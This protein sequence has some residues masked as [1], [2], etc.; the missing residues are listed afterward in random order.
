MKLLKVI[1][2]QFSFQFESR[3]RLVLVEVLKRYPSI[4]PGHER[5]SPNSKRHSATAPALPEA[6]ARLLAEAL[7][8]QRAENRRQVRKWLSDPARM[9]E[10]DSHWILKVPADQM[11]WLLQV[12]NEVRVGSWLRLGAPEPKEE[13]DLINEKTA[14]DFWA[15]DAAG[16]LQARFLEALEEQGSADGS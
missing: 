11:E 4:P 12:L 6:T 3:E 5:M 14:A 15:M 16:L 7:A 1:E 2:G 8:E 13:F 9:V 10:S